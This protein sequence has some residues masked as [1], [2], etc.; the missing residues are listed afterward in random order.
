MLGWDS[1]RFILNRRLS[2]NKS[3]QVGLLKALLALVWIN[4][5]MPSFR[6]SQ[7]SQCK[8]FILLPA[9]HL[10]NKKRFWKEASLYFALCKSQVLSTACPAS[11]VWHQN[12]LA[13]GLQALITDR[14]ILH[15]WL[16][17]LSPSSPV[18]V[19]CSAINIPLCFLQLFADDEAGTNEILGW[20]RS[21]VLS[22]QT[23]SYCL[24]LISPCVSLQ[25]SCHDDSFLSKI[26]KVTQKEEGK[27]RPGGE[28]VKKFLDRACPS[29]SR[30]K[31]K[32]TAGHGCEAAKVFAE[33][34]CVFDTG[35]STHER[36]TREGERVRQLLDIGL[37]HS[38]SKACFL[39]AQRSWPFPFM[40]Q[41]A[42]TPFAVSR[43]KFGYKL[44]AELQSDLGHTGLPIPSASKFALHLGCWMQQGTARGM[45]HAELKPFLWV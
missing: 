18:L 2:S 5:A 33:C 22:R 7:L 23:L 32:Y 37:W 35:D 41:G 38:L 27:P 9:S 19:Q 4:A 10:P 11:S 8:L 26:A 28:G 31:N 12:S 15:S 25:S 3:N 40:Q 1:L 36:L 13:C 14:G 17:E 42:Q 29:R 21:P 34:W 45:R 43:A 6:V 24:A 20:A 44:A 16:M 39:S 30:I